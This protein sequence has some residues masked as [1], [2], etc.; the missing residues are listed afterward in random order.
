LAGA[1]VGLVAGIARPDSLRRRVLSLGARVVAERW[2]AD[3]YR[4]R[5]VDLAGLA[6]Q[7]P[8]WI[9]TEKDAVKIDA[10]WIQGASLAVLELELE[11][12][13]AERLLALC[14]R[15]L[16]RDDRGGIAP[17]RAERSRLSRGA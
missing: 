10:A 6:G 16:A 5:A 11:V 13:E 7:A 8:L 12:P 9:T 17:D 1:A 15:K 4:Y 2:F 3:H 14:E